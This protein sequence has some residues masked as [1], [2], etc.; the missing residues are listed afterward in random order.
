MENPMNDLV[1]ASS[2]LA[3][4]AWTLIAL[5]IICISVIVGWLG[6]ATIK[7]GDRTDLA[8]CLRAIADIVRAFRRV[9]R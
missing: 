7:A 2:T 4:Y 9:Q 1:N 6:Y 3:A 5:A 8:A